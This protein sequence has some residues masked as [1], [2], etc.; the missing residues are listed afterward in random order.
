MTPQFDLKNDTFS[1]KNYNQA[2]PFS[3]F[4]PGIA[5]PYGKPMWVFYT[6]RGQ[7]VASFGVRNKDNAILEFNPANKAY[8]DTPLL[9]FRTFLRVRE[10]RSTVFYEPFCMQADPAC[11]Q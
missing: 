3:S 6:N 5:G 1:I 9:G 11:R 10:G 7:C 4:L 8:Q 2:R